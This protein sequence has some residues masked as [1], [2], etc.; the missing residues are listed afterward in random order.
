MILLEVEKWF[1]WNSPN[2]ALHTQPRATPDP[3]SNP[4]GLV[5]D[6]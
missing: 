3:E 1:F 2:G 4:L 5:F 6:Q